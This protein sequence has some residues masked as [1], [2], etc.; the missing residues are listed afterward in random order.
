MF[1]AADKPRHIYKMEK[2]QY[3]KLLTENITKIYNKKSNK[4]KISNINFT[5]KKITEKLSMDDRAQIMNESEAYY[6]EGS[7]G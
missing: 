5:T 2:Q 4:K 6:C 1:L 7:Q 3:T